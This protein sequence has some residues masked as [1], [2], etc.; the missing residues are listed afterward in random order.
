MTVVGFALF[1]TAIGWC[2]IGW[3]EAGIVAV[4]LPESSPALVRARLSRRMA[5]ASEAPPPP[6]VHT[7]IGAICDLLAGMNREIGEVPLDLSN[8]GA[9]EREVYWIARAIPPGRTLTYGEIAARLKQPD[10]AREVGQALARN[11]FPIIV[12]CHRVVASG[13]KLGGFSARGGVMTKRRMLEIER[14]RSSNEPDLF[15]P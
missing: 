13:G 8:V 4:Q 3:S 15:D 5:G 12:P 11:P 6:M 10:A 1:E 2:G 9:F 14:A 7:T